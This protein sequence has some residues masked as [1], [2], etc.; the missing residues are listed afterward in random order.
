MNF[1]ASGFDVHQLVP[2]SDGNP[3]ILLNVLEPR[4]GIIRLIVRPQ[5]IG[6]TSCTLSRSG[7]CTAFTGITATHSEC[8]A[9]IPVPE[10][11]PRRAAGRNL[12]QAGH[13]L[14]IN[15]GPRP[16]PG[17]GIKP[18]PRFRVRRRLGPGASESDSP[19]ESVTT[20]LATARRRSQSRAPS[21]CR[22]FV[23]YDTRL[24]SHGHG[25]VTVTVGTRDPA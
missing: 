16:G 21:Q 4:F 8:R 22:D 11:A 14:R 15:A 6:T 1:T 9:K 23:G 17:A 24:M 13:V 12:G 19:A 20:V 3:R 7:R 2:I 18:E 25:S 5:L 10:P